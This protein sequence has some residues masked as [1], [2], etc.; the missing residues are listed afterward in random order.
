MSPCGLG[1]T[2]RPAQGSGSPCLFG[3][4]LL[5][6]R[7]A[8][9]VSLQGRGWASW[10]QEASGPTQTWEPYGPW[11]LRSSAPPTLQ[12]NPRGRE[13]PICSCPGPT[14]GVN[15]GSKFWELA[16][17]PAR[18]WG[19]CRALFPQPA[20]PPAALRTPGGGW[21]KRKPA[22]GVQAPC[23]DP[24]PA[25]HEHGGRWVG[26]WGSCHA[27][28]SKAQ[29]RA[30]EP[31]GAQTSGAAPLSATPPAAIG[32]STERRTASAPLPRSFCRCRGRGADAA[33][34]Q[35]SGGPAGMGLRSPSD[36][37][38]EWRQGKGSGSLTYEPCRVRHP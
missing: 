35:R 7:G 6:G 33:R 29:G 32:G 10:A 34:T 19:S 28:P 26:K 30:T 12:Q 18:P 20:R 16:T 24:R 38:L 17:A 3:H 25:P 21:Q 23:L 15:S 31:R 27:A 11:C 14:R 22:P 1:A 2:C 9:N 36:S 13:R 8:R 37:A 4:Q 5:G